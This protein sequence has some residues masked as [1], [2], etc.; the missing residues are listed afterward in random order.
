LPG[1]HLQAV[2]DEQEGRWTTSA[3]PDLVSAVVLD[4][5]DGGVYRDHV[6]MVRQKIEWWYA[7]PM[8]PES[9]NQPA[10]Q[11]TLRLRKGLFGILDDLEGPTPDRAYEALLALGL[12]ERGGAL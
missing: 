5:L 4:G 11:Q 12:G 6:A 10:V 3:P 1:P 9:L 2:L 7:Q 8:A